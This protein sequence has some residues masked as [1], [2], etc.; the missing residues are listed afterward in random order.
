MANETGKSV[1]K[2]LNSGDFVWLGQDKASQVFN[3]SGDKEVR[4]ILFTLKS[5][6]AAEAASSSSK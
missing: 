1:G 4:I 3:N 6:G 5:R 2:L